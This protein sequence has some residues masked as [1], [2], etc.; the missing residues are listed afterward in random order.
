MCL[1]LGLALHY[2]SVS[3]LHFVANPF[4]ARARVRVCVTL[5]NACA[6]AGSGR[7]GRVQSRFI[8]L[9]VALHKL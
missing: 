3:S 4:A 5:G 6:F 1:S 2:V 8:I 7:L 9:A